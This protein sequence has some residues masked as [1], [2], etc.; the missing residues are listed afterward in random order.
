MEPTGRRV[1]ALVVH[2]GALLGVLPP[3]EVTSP[4]WS[5]VEP[6]AAELDRRLG[7]RTAVLRMVTATGIGMR[8]GEV[9]Y[10]AEALTPPT[11]PPEWDGAPDPGVLAPQE[12][13]MRWAE[14]GGPARVLDWAAAELRA[15]EQPLTGPPVQ[16][17]SWNLS[18]LYR[19]PTTAGPVWIKCTPPFLGPEALAAGYVAQH[20]PD[21]V[22]TVLASTTDGGCTLM[23]D[24]PGRDCWDADASTIGGVLPRYV[25]VQAAL[26]GHALPALPDRRVS[27]LAARAERLLAPDVTGELDAAERQALTRVVAELPH[28]A[29]AIA[30]AGLPE[31]LL[32]GDFHP[33]NWRSDGRR[34]V[35]FDWCEGSRGHPACDVLRLAGWLPAPLAELAAE[36]WAAEWRAAVPGCDPD[37][38]AELVRPVQH[39]EAALTYQRFLDGIEPDERRYHEGDPA[40]QIREALAHCRT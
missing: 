2:D 14:P 9:T 23:A 24:V 33:G 21:L 38:A 34:H 37:R 35:V 28:R 11:S 36:L 6:V 3:F 25:T 7:A 16:V 27:T 18:C 40:D 26:A 5:D 12:H 4:W 30:A 31:T 1:R 17:K 8:G 10:V 29:A 13:R 15:L 39:L 20:D 19:L 32:H 22:P